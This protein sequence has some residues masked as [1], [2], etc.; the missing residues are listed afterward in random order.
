MISGRREAEVGG[1]RRF[2]EC[3]ETEMRIFREDW[4]QSGCGLPFLWKLPDP[5]TVGESS[6]V[7]YAE[8][9]KARMPRPFYWWLLRFD[10]YRARISGAVGIRCAVP[11]DW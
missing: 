4:K 10:L 11:A 7:M 3:Q 9:E 6:L 2:R 8:Q 1:A 5:P